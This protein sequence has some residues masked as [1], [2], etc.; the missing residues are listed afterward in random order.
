MYR[1]IF[2]FNNEAIH[3]IIKTIKL[4][5]VCTKCNAASLIT[6]SES[7]VFIDRVNQMGNLR[8]KFRVVEIILYMFQNTFQKPNVINPM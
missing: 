1:N 7:M 2:H 4:K 3:A 5:E 6:I 8:F